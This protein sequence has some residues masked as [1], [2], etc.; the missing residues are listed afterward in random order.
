[1]PITIRQLEVFEEVARRGSYTRAADV[2]H[3]SQPAV[4]MQVKQLE[5]N[6]G[7]TLFEQIGKKIFLTQAGEEL[8]IYSRKIKRSLEDVE[9]AF[10]QLRGLKKGRLTVSAVSTASYFTTRMMAEF[11]RRFPDVDISLSVINREQLL[12][13]LEDNI[14]DLVVMGQIREQERISIKTQI[15]MENPLVVIARPGHVLETKK[16]IPLSHFANEQFV[17]RE[18][19]SGTRHSIEQ[20]FAKRRVPFKFSMELSDNETIKQAVAEGFSLAIV[21][22]HTLELELKTK[23]VCVLDVEG[24]PI[25]RNW[26]VAHLREKRLSPVASAFKEFVLTEA[27]RFIRLPDTGI[28]QK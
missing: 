25:I 7:L 14:P 19:A 17:V 5:Q 4:S 26:Y 6:A 12:Q 10:E 24:F 22:L 20:Y 27:R 28:R 13:Q 3:L 9:D 16:N 18:K 21:S 8:Y 11:S 15:F 1:M 2:L 23:R